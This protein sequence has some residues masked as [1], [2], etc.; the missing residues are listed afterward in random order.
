MGA[1]GEVVG[2]EVKVKAELEPNDGKA[3]EGPAN[4]GTEQ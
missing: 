4:V 2:E 3:L 1:E